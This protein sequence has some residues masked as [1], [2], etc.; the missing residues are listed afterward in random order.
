MVSV[1]ITLA[2]KAV[3]L[4][5]EEDATNMQILVECT[6]T[7]FLA[8]IMNTELQ[9]HSRSMIR[10][11]TRSCPANLEAVWREYCFTSA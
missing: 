10:H 3:L 8:S 1:V 2:N 6:A 7:S 11:T 9:E 5:D 4:M